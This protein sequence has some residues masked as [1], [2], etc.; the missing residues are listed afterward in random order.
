MLNAASVL[1][2]ILLELPTT[3]AVRWTPSDMI[4]DWA[5]VD[6]E[7]TFPLASLPG[8][9]AA[10]ADGLSGDARAV[11]YALFRAIL[12]WQGEL[13]FA[14]TAFNIRY[15][16]GADQRFG[17]FAGKVRAQYVLTAFVDPATGQVAEE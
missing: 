11:A 7:V 10:A 13:V 16:L 6:G 8:L 9:D 17:T 4:A 2:A 15:I 3:A 5:V 12:S 1:P 14:P